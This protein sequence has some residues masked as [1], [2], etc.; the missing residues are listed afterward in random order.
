[1]IRRDI[2]CLYNILAVVEGETVKEAEKK[3][4][5]QFFKVLEPARGRNVKLHPDKLQLKTTRVQ[6]VDHYSGE[7]QLNTT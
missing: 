4:Y 3:H 1:M 2:C 5:A 7:F 6:Y